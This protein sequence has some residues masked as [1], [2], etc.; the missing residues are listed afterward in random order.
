MN[1]NLKIAIAVIIVII[2][3]ISA[4]LVIILNKTRDN[5]NENLIIEEGE[6]ETPFDIYKEEINKVKAVTVRKL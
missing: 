3:L 5:T 2:M 4:I 1:K 6:E